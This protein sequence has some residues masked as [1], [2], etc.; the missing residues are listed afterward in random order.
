MIDELHAVG[1]FSVTD[2][3]LHILALDLGQAYANDFG[4]VL[5]SAPHRQGGQAQFIKSAI[6]ADNEALSGSFLRWLSEHI[7]EPLTL[8]QLVSHEH[9]SERS[10][11]RKFRQDTGLSVFDWIARERVTQAKSLLETT[12]L[13]VSE[14]AAMVGFGSAES[15][16]RNFEKIAGIS[17]V[18]YRS[19]FRSA[20]VPAA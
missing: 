16:R 14:I 11:V 5:V 9:V 18:N 12:S 8:A 15:L 10:L 7:D 13:R 2:L 3:S 17:A 1:V 20:P 19:M 6:R 4:R